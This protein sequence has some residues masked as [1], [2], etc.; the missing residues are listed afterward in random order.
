MSNRFGIQGR[1]IEIFVQFSDA[2]GTHVNTDDIPTVAIY[3]SNGT[4]QQAATR[5]GVGLAEDPGIYSFTYSI[6]LTGPDGYYTDLWTAKIGNETISSGF[7]FLVSASS[8]LE[9]DIEPVY[10]PGEDIPFVFTQAETYGVNVLLKLIKPRLKNNGVRKIPDGLGGYTTEICNVFTDAELIA[11]LVNS[12]S[13]FN[14]IPHFSNFLF[15]DPQIYTIFADVIVQGAVLLA[16]A[17]QTL[18]ERGRE[19]VITD[20]GITYQPP[21]I[22]EILNSQYTTQLADYKDK[23]KVIKCNLKPSPRGLGSWRVSGIAPAFLRLRHLRQRQ[24]I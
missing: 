9:E 15:S 7:Q 13:E 22:S 21:T 10:Y 23:V 17:A 24:I 11:F 14:Q 20:N 2:E 4:L 12:L 19:F 18:I 8:E 1:D 5:V 3:D 16:L 6:P